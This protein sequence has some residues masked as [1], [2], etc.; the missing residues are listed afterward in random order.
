M[1][2]IKLGQ[3]LAVTA[4]VALTTTAC[5]T[6][7]V[8]TAGAGTPA[9]STAA[10]G[11]DCAG[12]T[13]TEGPVSVTDDLGRTVELD[14]PAQRVVVLEWQQI[15][16]VLTLCLTP[17]G[18]A[19]AKGYSTWVTA[20]K[21][22][23]GVK[24]VG[25]RGEPN[26]DAVFS[27]NPDLVIAEVSAKDDP[28][29]KKLEKYDVPV[30]ATLGADASDPIQKMKDTFSLIGQVTGRTDRANAVIEEFDAKLADGKQAMAAAD[31]ATT[32]F[33][34]FD[35]WLDGGNVAIRPFGKGSLVGDLGEQLGLTNAWT[36]DVD[37]AY[38][39]GQT[40]IEGM[41]KVGNATLLYTST[42]D[43]SGDIFAELAKSRVWN[44]LPSVQDGRY[45]AF[46][47]GIWTFGGPRSSMQVI[48]AYVSTLAG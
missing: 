18:V 41:T 29:L 32:D 19:D 12:V 26:L 13:P 40:D 43:S 30:L 22:P 37:P 4:A 39:L 38:G 5:G 10:A 2:T 6:S 11:G 14:Q 21:L 28:V 42:K 46:P 8:S 48:D 16:D 15:E 45:L 23:E 7:E 27:A 3:I 35:G 34:Y 47:Q 24:D 44:R 9:T 31:L 17:V 1:K 33:V 20:E 36:G 25:V